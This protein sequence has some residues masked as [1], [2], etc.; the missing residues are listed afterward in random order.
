MEDFD[1]NVYHCFRYEIHFQYEEFN[2]HLSSTDD[3]FGTLINSHIHVPQ[4]NSRTHIPTRYYD[5]FL[6][7]MVRHTMRKK[8]GFSEIL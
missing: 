3:L 2:I 8:Q 7:M 4:Y 6:L 5:F 1:E